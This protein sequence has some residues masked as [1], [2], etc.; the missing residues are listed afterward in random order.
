MNHPA[1]NAENLNSCGHA[2]L[3][4]EYF[5]TL[6]FLYDVQCLSI[7]NYEQVCEDV[8]QGKCVLRTCVLIVQMVAIGLA[9]HG[10]QPLVGQT[11]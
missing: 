11:A 6:L 7:G 9:M 3:W 5:Q 4:Q 8:M 2:C 10:C 1:G